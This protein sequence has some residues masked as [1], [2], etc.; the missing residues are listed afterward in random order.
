MD[1]MRPPGRGAAPSAAG[2]PRTPT[3]VLLALLLAACGGSTAV[4]GGP[5]QETPPT[6]TPAS[7]IPTPLPVTAV[8]A[9]GNRLV[10]GAGRPM[11]LR[12]VNR[13]GTEYACVQ[14]WGLFDGATD[15]AAVGAIAAWKAN[16][17]RVP[18]NESCWLGVDGVKA[19]YGGAA[20]QQAIAAWV[21]RLRQAGLAVILEL[22]W[23]G[24]GTTPATGQQ[25]MPNRARTP[26]LWRQVANAYKGDQ[27][28][29]FD[30]FNEPFPDGNR[31]TPEAW[32]C[33]RDGGTCAGMGYEAAGMQ[34]LV[35][36]VRG[37]G[38]ANL[39]LVGGV[40]YAN[41]LTGWLANRPADPL[42]NLAAAWHV[43]NFNACSSAT[44]WDAYAAPVAERVPLVLGELGD[45]RSGGAFVNALMDW[46][47][48]RPGGG[49]YLAWVWN[50]WGSPLD[51]ITAYDGTPTAYGRAF[52]DRFAR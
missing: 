19:Q 41:S 35:T 40:Q 24:P 15:A 21:A 17:V 16:V 25:P 5:P 29:V 23:A 26:E 42:D 31:D 27:G 32:R 52:R 14:G 4:A 36:A 33:W 1:M 9:Q 12:G 51:L 30:L 49:S 48:A 8:R 2:W 46:M 11:R 13:S 50:V 10:D 44:C 7:A 6:A 3:L 47:D 34:E 28:V 39:I 37:T 43:Y 45:D 20:Y 22:H 38:A 18:L